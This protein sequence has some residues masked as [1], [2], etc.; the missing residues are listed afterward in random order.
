MARPKSL[1]PHEKV[2]ISIPGDLALRLQLFLTS[3]SLG[4]VPVG[5]YQRFW[6]ERLQEFFDLE[7]VELPTGEVIRVAKRDAKA[8]RGKLARLDA[9][10]AAVSA[11]ATR[12][13]LAPVE[14]FTKGS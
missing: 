4:R 5:A 2:H 1:N 11:E 14:S 9:A 13:V 6:T 12:A 3:P 7:V 10:G 8:V